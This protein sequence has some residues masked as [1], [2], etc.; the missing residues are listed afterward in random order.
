[1][2]PSTNQNIIDFLDCKTIAIA[3]ASRDDK[4]FSAKV[5]AHLTQLGYK[6]WFVN[7]EF[8]LYEEGNNRVKSV[9]ALPFDVHHLLILTPAGQTDIVLKQAIDLG[10]NN[11]WIQQKSETPG[12]L[13]LAQQ[14]VINVVHHNCIFMFTE[15][16][17]IHKFHCALKKVFGSLPK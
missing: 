6:L 7:P 10:I 5:A 13:E 9:A 12:A 17:G 3:G 16:E 14:H 8:E 11:I 1:M 4:S 15:P 2:K